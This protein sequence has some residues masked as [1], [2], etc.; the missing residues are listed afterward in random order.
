MQRSEIATARQIAKAKAVAKLRRQ[1]KRPSQYSAKALIEMADD[2]LA[3]HRDEVMHELVMQR[4][5]RTFEPMRDK[6]SSK[7][8][9]RKPHSTGLWRALFG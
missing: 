3:A 6:G 4:W 5:M 2:Y 9:V 7:A 1:D 8:A